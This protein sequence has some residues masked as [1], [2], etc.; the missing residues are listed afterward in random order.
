[1]FLNTSLSDTSF[2]HQEKKPRTFEDFFFFLSMTLK[3][4]SSLLQAVFLNRGLALGMLRF[5]YILSGLF[6]FNGVKFCLCL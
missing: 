1:M 5:G 4:I 6:A 2:S 3:I